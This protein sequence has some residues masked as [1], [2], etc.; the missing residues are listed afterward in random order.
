[1]S[2]G[3]T[4]ND[5]RFFERVGRDLSRSCWNLNILPQ[6]SRVANNVS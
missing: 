2:S 5:S 1:M 4:Q 3:A 6:I